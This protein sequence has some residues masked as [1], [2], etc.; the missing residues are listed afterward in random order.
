MILALGEILTP[1]A[2]GLF[3]WSN[4]SLSVIRTHVWPDGRCRSGE[5]CHEPFFGAHM[6]VT[7]N[8]FRQRRAFA[9]MN[10]LGR[11]YRC[12][13]MI[14]FRSR[15]YKTQFY[16]SQHRSSIVNVSGFA[17]A[18]LDQRFK[19]WLNARVQCKLC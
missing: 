14:V 11:K 3:A 7:M 19:M 18:S 12:W 6:P 15:I 4:L 17:W 9:I 10:Q 16:S 5:R 13:H 2:P 8:W 1:L